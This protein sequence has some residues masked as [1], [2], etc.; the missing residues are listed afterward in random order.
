MISRHGDYFS[1]RD[2]HK[3]LDDFYVVSEVKKNSIRVQ[4]DVDRHADNF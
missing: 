1:H 3:K 2:N 4:K